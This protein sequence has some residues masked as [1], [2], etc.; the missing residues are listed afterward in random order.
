MSRT[1]RTLTNDIAVAGSNGVQSVVDVRRGR[2]M[3]S[4][5]YMAVARL[6]YAVRL[7]SHECVMFPLF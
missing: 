4:M 7:P 5:T 3:R 1:T 6:M 2:V